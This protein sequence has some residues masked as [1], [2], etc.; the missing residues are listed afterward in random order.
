MCCRCSD[1]GQAGRGIEVLAEGR[2]ETRTKAEAETET[3][4]L[5]S[6]SRGRSRAC[7]ELEKADSAVNLNRLLLSEWRRST[8]RERG[9]CDRQLIID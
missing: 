1:G 5:L 3:E 9:I 6:L 4:L 7:G 2:A 8:T